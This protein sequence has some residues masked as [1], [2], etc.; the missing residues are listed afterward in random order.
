MDAMDDRLWGYRLFLVSHFHACVGS[1]YV[2]VGQ[3]AHRFS[4]SALLLVL[5][6]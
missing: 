6:S 4:G 1:H 5:H 3:P 2:C